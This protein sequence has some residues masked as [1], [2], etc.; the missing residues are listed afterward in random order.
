MDKSVIAT[1]VDDSATPTVLLADL[2]VP[3]QTRELC[4]ID[5]IPQ[6]PNK[7]IEKARETTA[8][9]LPTSSVMR[10]RVAKK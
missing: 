3:D 6:L 8:A 1:F 5:P 10:R 4:C 2:V 9:L 7:N